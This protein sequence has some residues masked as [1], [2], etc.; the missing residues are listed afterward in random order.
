[1]K[2]YDKINGQEV[3]IYTLKSGNIEADICT[4]G[5]RLNAL[6]VNGTDIAIGFDSVKDYLESNSYAGATIGRVANRIAGGRFNLG[7]KTYVLN[8][9]NGENHLHGG[10]VGFDKKI[11][12]VMN[13]SENSVTMRYVSPDGEENYPGRLEFTVTFTVKPDGFYTGY[14]AVSDEDTLWCP[15]NHAYFNMNGDGAGDCRNNLLQINA[16]GYTPV[17]GGLIPICE[18]KPVK[19]TV[20]D[21]NTLKQ[22]GGDFGCE[23]LKATNGYD[24]NYVLKSNHAAHAESAL[25]GVKMDVYTDMPCIQLYTGGGFSGKGKKCDYGIW[26]GFCLEPQYCPNAINMDGVEKPILKKGE[27]KK[28]YINLIFS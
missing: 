17:D 12:E 22:I 11:F 14:S 20:F 25:S 6:R 2:L 27:T 1:M 21:F 18:S 9:N 24:H 16:D 13:S 23:E 26:S 15:T 28:H 4:A 7:G 19:G 5:A 3:Y 8:Q 10:N